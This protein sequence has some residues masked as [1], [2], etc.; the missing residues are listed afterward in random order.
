MPINT[1]Q[2]AALFQTELDK[3]AVQIATSG[4]MEEN[5]GDVIYNGGR[6]IKIP[7][8]TLQGLGDYDRDEGQPIGSVGFA[9]RTYTMSQDRGRKFRL[10]ENDINETNF[11]TAAARVMSEFQRTQVVPEIDAYRY[12]KIANL[13]G[14][15]SVDTITAANVM[16]TLYNQLYALA[17]AGVDINN[18]IVTISYP[19]FAMINMSGDINR[20]ITVSD[21][22]QGSVTLKIRDLDG[23]K[24][25]PVSSDR[26]KT[27]YVF[28]DGKT[29]GQEAG[30][31]T[32]AQDAASINWIICPRSAPIA[33]SKTDRMKIITPDVNQDGDFYD[34][35]YHKYHDLIL[36]YARRSSV[37]VSTAAAFTPVLDSA[38]NVDTTNSTNQP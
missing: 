26:L 30:G 24:L 14:T 7:E 25:I 4:W 29:S 21:F 11:G 19:L 13:A 35:H 27:A 9:Y 32:P 16:P 6:D 17:N 3:H 10:D 8:L 31:F 33:I 5:A 15:K 20:N 2:Y 23:A 34:L 28:R 22:Q 1:L 38:V 37:I 36:P 12:S 18:I